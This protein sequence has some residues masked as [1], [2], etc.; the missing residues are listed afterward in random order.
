VT[1]DR[2][3]FVSLFLFVGSLYCYQCGDWTEFERIERR[4]DRLEL[5]CD[6]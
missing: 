6:P 4:L 5:E 2:V 3:L 1:G